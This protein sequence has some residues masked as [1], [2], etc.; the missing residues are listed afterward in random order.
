MRHTLMY[1]T[2]THNIHILTN[3]LL[4]IGLRQP[5]TNLDQKLLPVSHSTPPLVFQLCSSGFDAV[6]RE[7]VEHDN[8]RTG[9][10]GLVCFVETLA[11]DFDFDG[12]AAGGFS[13]ADG[14][15]NTSGGDDMVVLEHSHGGEI[16]AVGVDAA[17]EHAVLFDEPEAGGRFA[18]ASEDVWVPSFTEEEQE[19]VGFCGDARAA[20][21]RVE[22]YALAEEELADWAADGCAVGYGLERGSFF[23]VPFNARV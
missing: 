23:D 3:I 11:L 17:D 12:E 9:C 19:A 15:G 18:G 6:G 20:G 7:I 10:N 16:N 2:R 14:V 1:T 4:N 13:S 5:A 21:E 22:G 8:V